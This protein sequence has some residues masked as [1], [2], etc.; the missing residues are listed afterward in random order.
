[1]FN[2]VKLNDKKLLDIA[3][4]LLPQLVNQMQGYEI[5]DFVLDMGT[6]S[7]LTLA[8]EFVKNH[9]SAFNIIVEKKLK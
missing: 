8:N 3:F 5:K 6:H 4:D 7:N 1:M 2:K 9:P